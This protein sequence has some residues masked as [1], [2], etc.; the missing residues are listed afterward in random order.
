MA[1]TLENSSLRHSAKDAIRTT[2]HSVK[3]DFMTGET[4]MS[5]VGL[6]S[7]KKPVH[8]NNKSS[9][10]ANS[11]LQRAVRQ[12]KIKKKQFLKTENNGKRG[13]GSHNKH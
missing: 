10:K 13:K 11:I 3:K 4:Q 6:F 5:M 7:D 12:I 1:N 8:Y 2:S 9:S